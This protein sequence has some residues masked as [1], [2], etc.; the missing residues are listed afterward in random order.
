MFC[1]RAEQTTMTSKVLV[2]SGCE[3]LTANWSI[4]APDLNVL[5][6]MFN[7]RLLIYKATGQRAL[8]WRRVTPCVQSAKVRDTGHL[9]WCGSVIAVI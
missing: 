5:T 3:K 1:I 7:D 2:P 9:S 4:S 8:R 6:S